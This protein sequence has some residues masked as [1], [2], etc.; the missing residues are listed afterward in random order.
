MSVIGVD[1]ERD[2]DFTDFEVVLAGRN[3][4]PGDEQAGVI[5][6][7]LAKGIGA[8][9]GDWV[10]VLTSSL[11]GLINA[12]DFQVV[13]IVRTGST[14]YDSVFVKVPVKLVQQAL[15]TEAVERVII[16]LDDTENL[17]EVRPQIEAS[18]AALPESYETRDWLELAGFYEAVVSLYSGLF[19]VFAAIVAVVVM[20]SVANTMSMAVFERMGESGA[21]RAIGATRGTIMTMF[22]F[23]GVCIGLIGGTVG[24]GISLA[25]SS[26]IDLVGGIPMPPPP[27][28]S[29]GYQAFLS[30][31]PSVLALGFAISIAATIISSIYPAWVASR[32]DIVEALQK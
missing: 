14:E 23:E 21:L 3:L 30:V 32:V 15:D 8:K 6:S 25:L 2:I 27:A 24:I 13:G 18:L 19:R 17:A 5:G 28:M 29:Q 20:F 10:T 1:P 16:V 4:L 31:S 26:G 9:I 11:D 22:I 7:E 12:V